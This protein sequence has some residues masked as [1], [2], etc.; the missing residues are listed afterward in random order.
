MKNL[1][2]V[3]I[4]QPSTALISEINAFVCTITT[5]LVHLWPVEGPPCHS[6]TNFILLVR[7]HAEISRTYTVLD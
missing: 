3:H 4:H 5:K 6:C 2:Y 7:N 1:I